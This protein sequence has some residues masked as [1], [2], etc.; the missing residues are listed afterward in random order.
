MALALLY[1]A[2]HVSDV[3][4]PSSGASEYLLCCVG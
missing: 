2:Q 4:S 1:I 3:N